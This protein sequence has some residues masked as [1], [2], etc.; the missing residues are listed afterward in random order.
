MKRILAM[1]LIVALFA[2]N[3]VIVL[4]NDY[5]NANGEYDYEYTYD[6][7]D[8]DY[9][10]EEDYEVV[11]L[12]PQVH[13]VSGWGWIDDWVREFDSLLDE[14]VFRRF[15]MGSDFLLGYATEIGRTFTAGRFE[16]EVVGSIAFEGRTFNWPIARWQEWEDFTLEWDEETGEIIWPDPIMEDNYVTEVDAHVFI[17][18]RDLTGVLDMQRGASLELAVGQDEFG[19]M[20]ATGWAQNIQVAR[21]SDRAYFAIQIRNSH[22]E[23]PVQADIS[24]ELEYFLSGF[25]W[26]FGFAGI[27]LI[28][29]LA[30]HDASFV[31]EEYFY[32]EDEGPFPIGDRWGFTEPRLA[33]IMGEDFNPLA[34]DFA[35]MAEG[36]INVHIADGNYIT[37]IALTDDVILRIQMLEPPHIARRVGMGFSS[38]HLIDTRIHAQ[39]EALSEEWSE[40]WTAWFEAGYAWEDFDDSWLVERRNELEYAQLQQLFF[41]SLSRWWDREMDSPHMS[42]TGFYVRDLD[43]LNYLDFMVQSTFYEIVEPIPFSFTGSTQV[44]EFGEVEFTDLYRVFVHDRYLDVTNVSISLTGIRFDVHETA[45]FID[46]QYENV[47]AFELFEIEFILSDGEVLQDLRSGG[48]HWS[49]PYAGD[50]LSVSS[51]EFSYFID[52][53]QVVGV[54]I[55]G[56][57][58]R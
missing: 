19:W 16:I 5:E 57:E 56:T 9:P 4:A 15:G 23:V 11:P 58:I 44:L 18:I 52:V 50:E 1:L 7:P 53:R 49:W 41:I 34:S 28:A 54:R 45:F 2:A 6:A 48:S 51:F 21:E 10:E 32:L 24:F 55:N 29:L 31:V 30:G 47:W 12:P 14:M 39:Q 3:T 36:E 25:D 8:Y 27:D 13:V 46:L 33:E 40:A 26:E 20:F 17:A 35:I 43:Q 38:V 37:N 42:E 22:E